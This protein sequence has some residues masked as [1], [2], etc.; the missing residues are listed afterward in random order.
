MRKAA[1][2]RPPMLKGRVQ[3]PRVRQHVNPLAYLNPP[4]LPDGGWWSGGL[5]DPAM[6]IHLDIGCGSG[7]PLSLSSSFSLSALN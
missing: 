7:I 5:L 4:E 1:S 6:P 2:L 3:L